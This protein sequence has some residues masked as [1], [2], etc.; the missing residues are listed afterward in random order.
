MACSPATIDNHIALLGATSDVKEM[1]RTGAVSASTA[2]KVVKA[3]GSKAG[4]TLRAAAQKTGKATTKTLRQ[5]KGE[6]EPTP[7]NV[8]MLVDFVRSTATGHSALKPAAVKLME[9]LGL[10]A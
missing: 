10:V 2:S 8:A 5:S 4:A 9:K 6:F 3:E 1:V 7:K